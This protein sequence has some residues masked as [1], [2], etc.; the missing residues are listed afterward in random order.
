MHPLY[1]QLNEKKLDITSASEIIY[2]FKLGSYLLDLR[3]VT[4]Q[5]KFDLHL[6]IFF[7]NTMKKLYLAKP[8]MYLHCSFLECITS[9]NQE[10]VNWA[11]KFK[12][13]Q[14]FVNFSS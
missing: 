13:P 11:E 1:N 8:K 6:A 14:G 3:F 5:D 7:L 9:L 10:G 4:L 2:V 12:M